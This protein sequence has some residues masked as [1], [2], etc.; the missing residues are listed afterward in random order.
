[1]FVKYQSTFSDDGIEYRELNR[2][3]AAL[4]EVLAM[5]NEA[6]R[7]HDRR[8]EMMRKMMR[9]VNQTGINV[10]DAPHRELLCE[11][12][13]LCKRY[14]YIEWLLLLHCCY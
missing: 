8:L 5:N 4:G 9:V 14:W 2:T 7:E 10:L 3:L 6:M 12:S 1:M 11:G 13:F